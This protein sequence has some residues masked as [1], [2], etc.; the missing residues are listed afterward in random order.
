[1]LICVETLMIVSNLN[2]HR[3]STQQGALYGRSRKRDKVNFS[4]TLNRFRPIPVA[5]RRSIKSLFPCTPRRTVAENVVKNAPCPLPETVSRFG[6]GAF[7]IPL[8][9]CMV[10]LRAGFS[11]P[12][13]LSTPQ[14]LGGSQQHTPS[15]FATLAQTCYNGENIRKRGERHVSDR[16]VRRRPG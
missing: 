16:G 10:T 6:Q 4:V 11:R 1:M 13:P 9:V 14:K 8:T 12:F 2:R 3:R 7:F 5:F 15:P